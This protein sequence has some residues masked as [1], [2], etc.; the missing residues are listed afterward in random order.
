MPLATTLTDAQIRALFAACRADNDVHAAR[1]AAML[2]VLFDTGIAGTEL[3]A[4]RLSAVTFDGETA[5]LDVSVGRNNQRIASLGR[6]ATRLL[7][8]YVQIRPQGKCDGLFLA[9]RADKAL[10]PPLLRLTL[11]RIGQRAGL[12]SCSVQQ[13]RTAFEMRY[14]CAGG[15]SIMLSRMMGRRMSFNVEILFPRPNTLFILD[16]LLDDHAA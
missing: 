14:V 10:T 15:S 11:A 8:A 13:C 12:A 5:T 2:A 7:R 3:C 1:D 9:D 6:H 4:L 16:V